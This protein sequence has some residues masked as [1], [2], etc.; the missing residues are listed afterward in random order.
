MKWKLDEKEGSKKMKELSLIQSELNCPKNQ[1]NS[2]GK[3]NYRSCED[4]FEGVKPLL[5]KHECSITV[6]DEL[7]LIGERYYIKATA[8]IR[9]KGGES[10][11]NT[12]YAR[13]DDSKKGMDSAQLTGA[14]SSYARKYSLNGLLLIDDVKDSDATNTHGK[15]QTTTQGRSY[16]KTD[17]PTPLPAGAQ[18]IQDELGTINI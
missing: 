14:T 9:N 13:E 16:P 1:Y 10:V 11:S 15:P 17:A 8:T 3:Y 5:K 2:F 4:I 12:A 7:V 18:A 6:E